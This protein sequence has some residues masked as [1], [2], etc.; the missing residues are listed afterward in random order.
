M[1]TI[2]K[3]GQ[4][5]LFSMQIVCTNT[6]LRNSCSDDLDEMITDL[7]CLSFFCLFELRFNVPVTNFSV[8]SRRTYRVLDIDKG[9][10][11]SLLNGTTRHSNLVRTQDLS[12]F[13][14]S[15]TL[16]LGHRVLCLSRLKCCSFP[17]GTRR[18]ND[19][20]TSMRRHDV[21]STSI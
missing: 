12:I 16:Q 3:S 17:A 4:R 15:D 8:R 19:I 1:S 21:A 5:G 14:E 20:S 9:V 18:H 10:N 2:W 11:V 13:L 7:I 6:H